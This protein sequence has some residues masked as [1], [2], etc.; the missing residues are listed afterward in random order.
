MMWQVERFLDKNEN[1]NSTYFKQCLYC[2]ITY[3]L[4][5]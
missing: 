1:S 4:P 3:C 5:D 2:F